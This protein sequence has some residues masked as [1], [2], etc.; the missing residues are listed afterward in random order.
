MRAVKIP[1][2]YNNGDGYCQ[3]G[4]EFLDT[5]LQWVTKKNTYSWF[6][7]LSFSIYLRKY[8]S[9]KKSIYIYSEKLFKKKLSLLR[10][11]LI[12]NFEHFLIEK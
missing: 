9:Y 5:Y 10:N 12:N 6:L 4:L 1:M 2:L 3:F 7:T 8:L 11:N